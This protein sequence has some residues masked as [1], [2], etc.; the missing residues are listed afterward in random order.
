MSELHPIS[1]CGNTAR[2]AD[3]IFIHGLGGDAF[4]T[5][6]YGKDDSASWP[7]WL[8]KEFADVAVW[9]LDYPASPSKWLRVLGWFSRRCREKSYTMAL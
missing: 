7:H 4:A 3:V 8:G 9:S 2:K 1:G 6:R 5:W